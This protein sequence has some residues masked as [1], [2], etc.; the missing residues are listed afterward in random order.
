MCGIAGIL[1][2]KHPVADQTLI[3][4]MT[5]AMAHRGPDAHNDYVHDRLALGH[6]RLSIIDLSDAANQPF[7]DHTG[8][9]RIVFNGEIYNYQ[10]IKDRL[11]DYPFTTNG[12]T[13]VL[14]AAYI[15][16]GIDS[17]TYL[18]GMFAFAIWDT[19]T[20]ELFIARD[21]MG[22]KPVY[23]YINDEFFFLHLRSGGYLPAAW[24]LKRS[25]QLQ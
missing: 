6:R 7:A 5:D 4:K 11:T 10:E 16:W 24:F 19:L 3:K 9:Y 13:E 25:I 21:R 17:L 18:K 22:V 1:Y 14:L 20:Q 8:R 15:K 2:F 12:D 23:Y